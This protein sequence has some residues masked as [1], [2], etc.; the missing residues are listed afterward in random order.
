MPKKGI[1]LNLPKNVSVTVESVSSLPDLNQICV[2]HFEN[3]EPLGLQLA[4]LVSPSKLIVAF[5]WLKEHNR[6]LVNLTVP[7]S[8]LSTRNSSHTNIAYER[9]TVSSLEQAK[10]TQVNCS[11]T[12]EVAGCIP[13]RRSEKCVKHYDSSNT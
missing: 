2:V 6:L 5:Q 11:G 10:L 3:G 12:A 4:L 1:V 13:R 7:S 8:T 9:C